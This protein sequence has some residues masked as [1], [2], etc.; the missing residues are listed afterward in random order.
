MPKITKKDYRIVDLH[1]L[2]CKQILDVQKHIVGVRKQTDI[3]VLLENGS[4]M[5]IS[6]KP[7]W[8]YQGRFQEH[9]LSSKLIL[10]E[11]DISRK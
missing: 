9:M 8:G 4:G 11:K 2:M 3:G 1:M 6:M 10:V 7:L 5:T